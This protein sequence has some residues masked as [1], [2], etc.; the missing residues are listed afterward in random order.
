MLVT[1]QD[2]IKI[3]NPL[4]RSGHVVLQS[5][6]AQLSLP[7]APQQQ[8]AVLK[9][10]SVTTTTAYAA[11]AMDPI[12]GKTHATDDDKVNGQY[13][14]TLCKK[15]FPEWP[16]LQAHIKVSGARVFPEWPLLQAHIK[17]RR[18]CI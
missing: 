2:E 18:K 17:V 8:S 4:L 9:R 7:G 16:L 10:K 13:Q 14:C 12:P 5:I 15:Q 3:Q 1:S 6:Q 11:A